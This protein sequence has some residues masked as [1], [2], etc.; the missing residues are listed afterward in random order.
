MAS[1]TEVAFVALTLK[2]DRYVFGA[3]ADPSNAHPGALDCS[4]L[5]S[6][7]LGRLGVNAPGGHYGQWKWCHDAGRSISVDQA[8]YTIGA[9]LF[10]D[11]GGGQGHVAISLGTGN[12]TIEA[13]G[14]AWGVNCFPVLGR[15]WNL[16]GGLFP[17]VDYA[18]RPQPPRPIGSPAPAPDGVNPLVALEFAIWMWKTRTCQQGDR[19]DGVRLIRKALAHWGYWCADGDY[20]DDGVRVFVSH[21]QSVHG[22]PVTGIVDPATWNDLY[23]GMNP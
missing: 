11:H 1:G 9:G 6:W 4:G 5:V 15:G 18:P 3:K 23:P 14:S 16:G 10:A 22:L 13:K 2:G 20:F 12:A 21:Y 17:H 19:S 7:A 8:R